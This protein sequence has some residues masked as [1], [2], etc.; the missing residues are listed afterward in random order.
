MLNKSVL[1]IKGGGEGGLQIPNL[2]IRSS[3]R[4]KFWGYVVVNSTQVMEGTLLFISHLETIFLIWGMI[5]KQQ[6][7]GVEIKREITV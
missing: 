4:N 3:F 2:F 1:S 6:P 7:R 5:L